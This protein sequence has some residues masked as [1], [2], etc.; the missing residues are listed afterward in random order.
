[1]E[2]LLGRAVAL[3]ENQP[4]KYDDNRHYDGSDNVSAV[5]FHPAERADSKNEH[6][7]DTNPKRAFRSGA[8]HEHSLHC[9]GGIAAVSPSA[10]EWVAKLAEA[11]RHNG[12]DSELRRLSFIPLLVVDEVGYIPFDPE[13]A[14]LMFRLDSA[15]YERDSIIV[16]SNKPFSACRPHA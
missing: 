16:T 7:D 9:D 6:R 15:R 10:N 4:K 13:A 1:L 8:R 14:N 12:L 5:R 11:E 3:S 2:G